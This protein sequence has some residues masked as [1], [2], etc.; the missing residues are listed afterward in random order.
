MKVSCG[1]SMRSDRG[2]ARQPSCRT[3]HADVGDLHFSHYNSRLE[4]LRVDP[5]NCYSLRDEC[6][7]Q[8]NKRLTTIF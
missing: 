3:F 8:E 5:K 6:S 1:M 7:I 4:I 2:G